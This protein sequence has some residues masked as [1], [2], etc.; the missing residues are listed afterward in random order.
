VIKS[1]DGKGDSLDQTL[2]VFPIHRS[3]QITQNIPKLPNDI[4]QL[5]KEVI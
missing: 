3:E 2:K 5:P 4:K 1:C